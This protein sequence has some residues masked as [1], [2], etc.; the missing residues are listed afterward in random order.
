MVDTTLIR[1]IIQWAVITFV[2][3]FILSRIMETDLYKK[4]VEQWK[5]KRKKEKREGDKGWTK[6]KN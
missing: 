5:K 4:I 2:L 1:T 3:V 6:L